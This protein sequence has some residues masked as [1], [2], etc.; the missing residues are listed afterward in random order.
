MMAYVVAAQG[1]KFAW[2][3]IAIWKVSPSLLISALRS[4]RHH[5]WLNSNN[6]SVKK[7]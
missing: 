2:S 1:A 4:A 6:K 3:V 5:I 7:A